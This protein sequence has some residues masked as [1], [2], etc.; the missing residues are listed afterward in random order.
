MWRPFPVWLTFN[1]FDMKRLLFVA[2]LALSCL[3]AH[4]GLS[5]KQPCSDGM[6]LQQNS[7][8][9]LWGFASPGA[10]VS[11]TTSWNGRSYTARADADGIW[12]TSVQ[13][14]AASYRPYEV[15][16]SGDGGNLVIRDVLIGEVWLA[17]GQ[18]NME[19]PLSGYRNAP[20]EN[21]LDVLTAAPMREKIRIFQLPKLQS[22]T[23]ARDVVGVWHGA[24]P[25]TR[26]AMSATAY[27]F[28]LKLNEVLDVPV[29]VVVCAYG[30]S[31]V[32]S[33]MPGDALQGYPD[34]DLSPAGMSAMRPA[35][36]PTLMYN[37][38]LSPLA[39]WTVKGFIFYQ[40]CSNVGY[41]IGTNNPRQE[42]SYADRLVKM[43]EVW[44][45]IWGDGDASLPFYE[46]EIAPCFYGNE[47]QNGHAAGL[48]AA[49]HEAAAR[50]PN[51]GI[52][53][54]ND[55]ALP[56]EW[57]NIHPSRK[58]PVGNRLAGLALA[59]QYGYADLPC[60]S[61]VALRAYRIADD[62]AVRV[63]CTQCEMG[64]RQIHGIEGLEVCGED[65]RFYPVRDVQFDFQRHA[66]VISSPDVF[67][68]CE[69][70][71]GWGD[72]VPGNLA[73]RSLPFAPF[74]LSVEE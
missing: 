45:R 71:Y 3:A 46:V 44:R 67:R 22:E 2:V 24:D 48:R 9:T 63:E 8:A 33:W 66:L 47:G 19:M 52:V 14:P 17:G 36:R 28:A 20:V 18:S 26:P 39:G 21:Y 5:V 16:I 42:D 72:F 55:L 50:I 58:Q 10:R 25:A 38:M 35:L 29:G 41:E 37:A 74:N 56:H 31:R 7:N 27:F 51:A 49:Q 53:V 30:G 34:V 23:P 69:V 1:R 32:E 40:G 11:V 15:R 64:L 62:R 54:T 12:R 70:R 73:D 43:V 59:R 61:P 4:A 57:D 6:V 13:T 60:E 65:G 68:I